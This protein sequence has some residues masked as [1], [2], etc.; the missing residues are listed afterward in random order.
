MKILK[1]DGRGGGGGG[2]W[3]FK[4]HNI[5]KDSLDVDPVLS[6]GSRLLKSS[7]NYWFSYFRP[8]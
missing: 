6:L 5:E 1:N 8:H 7:T 2:G 3:G 4:N